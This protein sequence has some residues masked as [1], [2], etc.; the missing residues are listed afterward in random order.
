MKKVQ[1]PDS[2]RRAAFQNAEERIAE[3][4][5]GL[6]VRHFCLLIVGTILAGC[7]SSSQSLQPSAA[8]QRFAVL[9]NGGAPNINKISTIK[10]RQYQTI[11]I[12]GSG[13][14]SMKPYNGDSDYLQIWD[15]TAGW[16]SGL[17]NSSQDDTVTLDVASWTQNKIVITGFTGGYGEEYWILN[18]G[19]KLEVNV[20]NAKTHSGPA[21]IH[22][23]VK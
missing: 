9:Q 10:P 2:R 6:T 12:S 15:L 21:T 17:I 11:T 3:K 7:S 20:W 8:Y 14:G 23:T 13:F 18:K 4:K 16:S 22:T 5:R 19:D 1:S